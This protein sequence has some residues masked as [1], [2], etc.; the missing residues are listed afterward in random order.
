M[1]GRRSRATSSPGRSC[2][3]RRAL[4]TGP[5]GSSPGRPPRRRRRAT[6]W[7]RSPIA[8][9][10]TWPWAVCATTAAGGSWDLDA[11]RTLD[12]DQVGP[13]L[14]PSRRRRRTGDVRRSS[15]GCWRWRLAIRRAGGAQEPGTTTTSLPRCRPRT[16]SRSR[17]RG[18]RPRRPVT[19]AARSSSACWP[20]VVVT[21]GGVPRGGAPVATSPPDGADGY[22]SRS[23][24]QAAAPSRNP[25][26]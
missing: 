17:T 2:A 23:A 6:T 13:P 11:T 21:I 4:S 14:P 24:S 1:R 10:P 20:L 16:S 7:S 9:S 22:P 5:P 18:R 3:P 15:P 19:E 26:R 25:S 12:A 8:P